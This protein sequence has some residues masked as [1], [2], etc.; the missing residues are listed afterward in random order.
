[1]NNNIS[2]H[3]YP[4]TTAMVHR[5]GDLYVQKNRVS[6]LYASAETANEKTR[7]NSELT[8]IRSE[9]STINLYI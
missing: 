3:T 1:M 9:I 4:S 6:N 2:V 8:Q 5:R 7:Y